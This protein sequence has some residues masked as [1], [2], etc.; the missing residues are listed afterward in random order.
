MALKPLNSARTLYAP[1][2]RLGA[3]Y[4]PDSSV[5]RGREVPLWTSRMVTVAPEMAP[6]FA[7]VTVPT[8]RPELPCENAGRLSRSTP[9]ITPKTCNA[10][11]LIF[12]R[13]ATLLLDPDDFIN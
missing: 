2:V 5:V 12:E 6:P 3:L 7:S 10:F 9:N 13:I 8:I 1:G 11:L 4:A